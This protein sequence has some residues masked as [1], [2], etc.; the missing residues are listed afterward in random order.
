MGETQDISHFRF[1]IWQRVVYLDPA[2]KQPETG[3]REALFLGIA[4]AHGDKMTYF[5]RTI[6][7]DPPKEKKRKRP[8]IIVRS[9]VRSMTEIKEFLQG[10]GSAD[11]LSHSLFEADRQ[12]QGLHDNEKAFFQP[13]PD[14][15]TMPDPSAHDK[16]TASPSGEEL[17]LSNILQSFCASTSSQS[18]VNG[19]AV[20]R[21]TAF[22]LNC[23]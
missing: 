12:A 10:G 16:S 18:H 4:D 7:S 8:Q 15:V 23:Q 13:V 21:N 14:P 9:V 6:P 19:N 5:L 2:A 17:T 11:D 22:Q 3:L 20:R 1:H